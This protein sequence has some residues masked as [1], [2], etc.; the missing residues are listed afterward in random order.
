ML[1]TARSEFF[2]FVVGIGIVQ[3]LSK[4]GT[5]SKGNAVVSP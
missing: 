5:G 4:C 2:V 1:T 3:S